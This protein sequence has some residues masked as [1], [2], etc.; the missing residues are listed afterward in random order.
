MS[1][2]YRRYYFLFIFIQFTLLSP[3]KAGN[4]VNDS[5]KY[6]RVLAVRYDKQNDIY[7]AIYFYNRYLSYKVRDIKSSYRLAT[8][9]FNARDYCNAYNNYDT[10]IHLD[11]KKYPLAYYFKGIV[12]MNL[13]KYTEAIDAF[14]K[15]R[16]LYKKNDNKF[17]YRR[18]AAISI[19]SATWARDS[20]KTSGEIT[21]VHPDASLNHINIDFAPFPVDENTMLYGAENAGITKN[22]SSVRQI[23]KAVKINGQWK[24]QGLLE[25]EVNHSEYNTGNAAVSSNGQYMYFT[26]MRKNWKNIDISEIFLSRFDGEKWLTPQKLPFPINDENYTSTQPAIGKN[27]RTGREIIYFV[28]DRPGGKGGLDIWYTEFDEKTNTFKEPQDLDKGVNSPGDECCPFY[29]ITSQTLY[30]SSKG[31]K[32]GYGG[33]DIFKA[34][35]AGKKWIEAFVLPKP[36][37]SSYDDYY[38]TILNTNKEGFFTSNRPGSMALDKG[39]CCDDIFAF[40]INECARIYSVGTV[41]NSVNDDIYNHLNEK[42]HLNLKAPDANI[43][44][45]DVPVELYLSGEKE[46]EEILISKATT[47]ANGNYHFELELNK[48]YKILIKNYGYFEKKVPVSTIGINCS[49]TINIRTTQ[50]DY[51]PKVTVRLNIYYDHNKYKLTD[52]AHRTI[53]STLMPLLDLF[54]KAVVE[55]GSHTDST[56]TDQYNMKL[57]QNRSES[58]VNY[59]ISKAISA[60]RLVAKGYG[61]RFPVAPN[62]NSDG[63]DNPEGRQL[64]RRTEIKIV[65]DISTFSGDE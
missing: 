65:G 38:F 26:R 32:T 15:F 7:N 50:I 21:I 64:N 25:G 47:D 58:V 60:E 44:L 19:E 57:S 22:I 40:R 9:C 11:S 3:I 53:D 17:N 39:S 56:G 46:G 42:Y 20:S 16:K 63:T 1:S 34:V 51:L 10:V 43:G 31:R 33:Y 49:D 5:V 54:Q 59:L 61:M 18:L 23:Y 36:V 14:T 2:Q 12:S 24:T 35:G 48:Q 6:Y 62:T 27:L 52:A 41:K 37:N 28:S 55:I 4:S 45:P 13:E 29:D 8:L 30:F